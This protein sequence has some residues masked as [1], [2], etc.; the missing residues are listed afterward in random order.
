M[1]EA[2]ATENKKVSP[3]GKANSLL[4]FNAFFPACIDLIKNCCAITSLFSGVSIITDNP[5]MAPAIAPLRLVCF[6]VRK[7]K[8]FEISFHKNENVPIMAAKRG[9]SFPIEPLMAAN[10][11]FFFL[12][13]ANNRIIID[14]PPL[15]MNETRYAHA[16][17][18][19][20]CLNISLSDFHSGMFVGGV[21]LIKS[22]LS[23]ECNPG[24]VFI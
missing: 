20:E 11:V 17:P 4:C 3:C 6:F 24:L 10:R 15:S 9:V 2:T 5:A 8:E 12:N 16:P 13:T 19:I 7:C 18:L 23:T 21:L 14:T 1:I 22:W